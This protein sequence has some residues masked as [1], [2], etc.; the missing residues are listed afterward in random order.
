MSN[1]EFILLFVGAL[2]PVRSAARVEELGLKYQ[3]AQGDPH[4]SADEVIE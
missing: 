3:I 4:L 1:W 2:L